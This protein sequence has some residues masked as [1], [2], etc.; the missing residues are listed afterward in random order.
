MRQVNASA[1][2]DSRSAN[3]EWTFVDEWQEIAA[4]GRFLAGDASAPLILV[5]FGDFECPFCR[6]FA[7]TL[8][9]L[10]RTHGDSLAVVFVHF[11][12]TSIHRLAIPAAR[13][14]ECAHEQG[15][16]SQY[17]DV[18]FE[19][20]ESL[21]VQSWRSLAEYAA[22][23]DLAAFDECV[24]RPEPVAAAEVGREFGRKLGVL[25]T[26]SVMINGW[27]FRGGIHGDELERALALLAQGEL[28]EGS[29]GHELNRLTSEH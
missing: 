8:K 26:P 12:L 5:E 3:R 18:L 9:M 28:A 4:A 19:N 6:R 16:F 13:A 15:R 27:L 10:Q 7:M 2:S 21:A 23:P 11:P 17:H 20:Q 29:I 22:V 24:A 1:G 25:G 14:S